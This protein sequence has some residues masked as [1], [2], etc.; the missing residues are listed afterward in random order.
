MTYDETGTLTVVTLRLIVPWLRFRTLGRRTVAGGAPRTLRLLLAR[1]PRVGRYEAAGIA[2]AAR[3]LRR[4]ALC[5]CPPA[6]ALRRHVL[7]AHRFG[8][9][10]RI[11]ALVHALLL[12]EATVALLADLDDL[13][14]AERALRR[15]EAVALLVLVDRVQHVRNVAHR[16]RRKLAIVQPDAARCTG[17]H[18]VI[19]I[20]TARATL[21]RIIML[22]RRHA[23]SGEKGRQ[24]KHNMCEFSFS[25]VGNVLPHTAASQHNDLMLHTGEPK[26]CP[27]S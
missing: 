22:C 25:F 3:S 17:E 21:G 5:P 1:Y 12:I 10:P 18:D 16:A 23:A 13:V 26:L 11:A 7:N 4:A 6:T 8:H 15:L 27:I 14:A 19:A 24:G 9:F 2:I 20:V